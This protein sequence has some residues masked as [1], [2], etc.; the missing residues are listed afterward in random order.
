MN[1]FSYAIYILM[2]NK[3]IDRSHLLGFGPSNTLDLGNYA[4]YS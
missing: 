1:D 3:S 4:I 2:H